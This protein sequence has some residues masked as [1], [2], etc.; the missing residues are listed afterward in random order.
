MFF[1]FQSVISRYLEHSRTLNRLTTTVTESHSVEYMNPQILKVEFR[2]LGFRV[3]VQ[4]GG[5]FSVSVSVSVVSRWFGRVV[6]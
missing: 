4:P 6:T 5:Q 2:D 1:K 3:F